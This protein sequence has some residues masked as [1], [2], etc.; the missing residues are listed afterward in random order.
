[1][2][3]YLAATDPLSGTLVRVMPA[4]QPRRRGGFTATGMALRR[5]PPDSKML[6]I[7][8]A[9]TPFRFIRVTLHYLA[10]RRCAKN[11]EI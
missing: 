2:N 9:V 5:P 1:M 8:P 10:K 11:A 7:P 3:L 4:K 6:S